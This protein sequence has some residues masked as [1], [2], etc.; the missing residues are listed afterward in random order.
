MPEVKADKEPI[1]TPITSEIITTIKLK[2]KV[3]EAPYISL[4][5]ISRPN[6]SVPN[7]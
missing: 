3:K 6:S 1:M 7:K 4:D 2:P 5:N